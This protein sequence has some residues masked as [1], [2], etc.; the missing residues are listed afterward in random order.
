ML[1]CR[2]CEKRI[3]NLDFYISSNKGPICS[4]CLVHGKPPRQEAKRLFNQHPD[5]PRQGPKQ[6][7]EQ[8][9]TLADLEDAVRCF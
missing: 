4:S 8:E 5:K 9:L 2:C 3:G 7:P 6:E 1:R